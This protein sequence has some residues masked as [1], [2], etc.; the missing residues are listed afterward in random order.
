L[1]LGMLLSSSSCSTQTPPALPIPSVGTS[2]SKPE[3]DPCV[4]FKPII[5][6]RLHDTPETIE[7]VKVHNAKWVAHCGMPK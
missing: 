7:A 3:V 2:A 5:F 4:V 1:L 6:S